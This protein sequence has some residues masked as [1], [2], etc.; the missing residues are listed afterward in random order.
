MNAVLADMLARKQRFEPEGL[1]AMGLD[2]LSALLDRL[3]PDTARAKNSGLSEQSVAQLIEQLGDD[4]YR[5]RESATE[6]LLELGAVVRA[7]LIRATRH[8]DA[9]IAWRARRILRRLQAE[10]NED[11]GGYVAAFTVYVE[12]IKDGERI[13]ELAERTRIALDRGM[14]GGGRLGLLERCMMTVAR[15]GKDE[16]SNLLKPL[17]K[18]EDPI[19]AVL[20]TR[21]IGSASDNRYFPALL[22]DALQH[23]RD[24]IVLAAISQTPNCW[25]KR[26]APEVKRLLISI[27]EGDNEP[28]KFQ[29]CFPLM[30]G[31]YYRQAVDYLLEQTRSKNQQRRQRA[32]SWIG[33][34]CNLGKPADAKLLEALVPLLK[35]PDHSTRRMAVGALAIYS[36]ED[37]VQN[38]VPLLDDPKAVIATEVSYRLLHQRDKNMLRRL[39]TTAAKDDP[40]QRIRTKAA[41]ILEQLDQQE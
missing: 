8:D 26:R 1:H 41:A 12:E 5:L 36:G 20:V 15:S 22:L 10:K 24:E 21:M 27:F 38:L 18:H 30:H 32:L 11:K 19:V 39:L 25:D 2:G 4:N 40:N 6:K 16:Y 33:D 14:P 35:S 7:P 9:E 29:A 34:S 13:R 37:V 28:L 23:D 17:L 31:Y 3:L